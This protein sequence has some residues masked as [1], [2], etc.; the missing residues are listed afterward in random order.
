MAINVNTVYTTVLSILNKEQRGYLTPYEF[1]QAATQ[2]QLNIFEKYFQDLDKQLRIPQT[3]F[4][5][6]YPISNIDDEISIF[7]C[8]GNCVYGNNAFDSPT[9]DLLSGLTI[10]YNDNPGAN[11]LAF[12]RLGTVTFANN[13]TVLKKPK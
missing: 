12:Y 2:V 4:D 9:T 8:F 10:V 11:Q 6:S 1:N 5:Y 13:T 7:K 3:D